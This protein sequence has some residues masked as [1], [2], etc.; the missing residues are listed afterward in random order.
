M[1]TK[2]ST[3]KKSVSVKA[4]PAP[5]KLVNKP[6]SMSMSISAADKYR[7][8]LLDPFDERGWGAR[9]PDM[10]SVPTKTIVLRANATVTTDANGVFSGMILPSAYIHSVFSQGT[11]APSTWPYPSGGSSVSKLVYTEP[12][13]LGGQLANYRIVNYGVRVTDIASMTNVSGYFGC[14][15]L[16]VNSMVPTTYLVGGY[17][18]ATAA[19]TLDKVYTAYGI[20]YSGTGDS[21]VINGDRLIQ[22]PGYQGWSG[23]QIAEKSLLINSKIGESCAFNFRQAQDRVH[24]NDV[25]PGL[26]TGSIYT[27]DSSYAEVNGFTTT[28]FHGAGFPANTSVLRLEFVYHLEGIPAPFAYSAGGTIQAGNGEAAVDLPGYFKALTDFA[29]TPEFHLVSGAASTIARLLV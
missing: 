7:L 5:V 25:G 10:V 8:C 3:K 29:K 2:K 21:A 20:P 4:T 15:N 24:G 19:D 26:A 1:N 9:V 17:N 27:G 23:M 22:Y 13:Y 6:K 14:V 16:Q 28:V 12:T 11:G 18:S